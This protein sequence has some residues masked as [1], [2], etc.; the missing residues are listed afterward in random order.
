M[1]RQNPESYDPKWDSP[2]IGGYG[3]DFSFTVIF[4]G[5]HENIPQA[6]RRASAWP[7]GGGVAH[8]ICTAD[9]CYLLEQA[10]E[11]FPTPVRIGLSDQQGLDYYKIGEVEQ[12][13]RKW[14]TVPPV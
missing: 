7:D 11:E 4:D 12:W 10:A 3:K 9:L 5:D 1:Y 8:A 6:D 13:K 2:L 14:L